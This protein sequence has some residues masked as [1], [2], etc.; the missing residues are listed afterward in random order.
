MPVEAPAAAVGGF[1]GAGALLSFKPSARHG[2]PPGRHG[3]VR[4][5]RSFTAF[6]PRQ[7]GPI[8][9]KGAFLAK[10]CISRRNR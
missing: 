5:H 4:G 10:G 1:S 8:F 2:G 9:T 6:Q 7:L 3:H